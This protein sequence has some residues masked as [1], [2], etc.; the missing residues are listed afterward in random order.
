M[1]ENVPFQ[2]KELSPPG[3]IYLVHYIIT[4]LAKVTMYFHP[5][6]QKRKQRQKKRSFVSMF[7]K[8]RVNPINN[9]CAMAHGKIAGCDRHFILP[10]RSPQGQCLSRHSSSSPLHVRTRGCQRQEELLSVP[11]LGSGRVH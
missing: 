6:E 7:K 8:I 2:P 10:L 4:A 5:G 9:R 3:V 1:A 11:V